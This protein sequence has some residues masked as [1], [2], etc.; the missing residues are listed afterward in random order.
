MT[1][2]NH[3]PRQYNLNN[4]LDPRRFPDLCRE[5][6]SCQLPDLPKSYSLPS[7]LWSSGGHHKTLLNVGLRARQPHEGR[8]QGVLPRSRL[9]FKTL[10][11][12]YKLKKQEASLSKLRSNGNRKGKSTQRAK[13]D[14]ITAYTSAIGNKRKKVADESQLITDSIRVV[15]HNKHTTK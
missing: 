1:Y 7:H 8:G 11:Q 13:L 9:A 10:H 4:L 15:S 2:L 12:Q 3:H 5:I 14:P 6:F